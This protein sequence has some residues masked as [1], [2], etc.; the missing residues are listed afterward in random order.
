MD[1][2]EIFLKSYLNEYNEKEKKKILH[3]QEDRLIAAQKKKKLAIIE[4]FLQKFVDLEI[5]VHHKDQYTKNSASTEHITPQKFQFYLVD[6]SKSWSP[7]ISILFEHPA[8]VE[9]AIPNKPDEEGVVVIKVASHHPDHYILEQK[10]QNF[11]SACEA[12]GRFLGK[13]TVR[14]A[15]DPKKYFKE[16]AAKK[17]AGAYGDFVNNVPDEPPEENTPTIL[18]QRKAVVAKENV[19]EPNSDSH[20]SLKKIGELFNLNKNKDSEE[21]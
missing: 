5:Y 9:I 20:M 3:S 15:K 16:Q 1:L 13:C 21:D 4:E 12:L 11:E 14:I 8:E 10:F 17:S 7:G 18:V 19:K 2:N 6:S